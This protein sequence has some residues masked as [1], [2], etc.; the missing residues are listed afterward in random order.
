MSILSSTVSGNWVDYTVETSYQ[1]SVADG[2]LVVTLI[3]EEPK[4]TDKSATPNPS[5]AFKMADWLMSYVGQP[6]EFAKFLEKMNA[7]KVIFEAQFKNHDIKLLTILDNQGAWVFPGGH[8]F[9]YENVYFSDKLDLISH[10][11]YRKPA[12]STY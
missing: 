12:S 7:N 11:N 5:T 3:G 10:I 2:E 6:G 8:T 9:S 1:I 4:V